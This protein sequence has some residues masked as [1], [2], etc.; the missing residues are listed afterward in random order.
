MG[1]PNDY[2]QFKPGDKVLCT[3]VGYTAL[4]LYNIYTVD[5]VRQGYMYP[6]IKLKEDPTHSYW[7]GSELVLVS[8]L[9]KLERAIYGV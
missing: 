4:R 3:K 8:D 2:N 5:T 9:T 7:A 6:F 1:I